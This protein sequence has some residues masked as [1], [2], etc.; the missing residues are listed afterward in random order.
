[1]APLANDDAGV[2]LAG[3]GACAAAAAAVFINSTAAPVIINRVN[4]FSPRIITTAGDSIPES[5][6]ARASA[7]RH[8]NT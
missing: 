3:A 8:L 2:E 7:R 1:M 4:M 6:T 5:G